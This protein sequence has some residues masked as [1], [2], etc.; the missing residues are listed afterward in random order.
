DIDAARLLM[1]VHSN[2]GDGTLV[3]GPATSEFQQLLLALA[4]RR[5]SV[6]GQ[7]G[8]VTGL[9]T[10]AYRELRGPASDRLESRLLRAEQSNTSVI[11]GD[12]LIL[13]LYRRLHPGVNPDL[14][15]GRFLSEE[16]GFTATP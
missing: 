12:R 16:R 14:E 6:R 9:Q 10:R 11:Y 5:R 7:Q 4:A 15:I 13:K 8:T 2:D 1:H 3:D